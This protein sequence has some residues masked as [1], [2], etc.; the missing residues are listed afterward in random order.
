MSESDELLDMVDLNNKV[1]GQAKREKVFKEGLLHRAANIFIFN[2]KGQVYLQK[3][4]KKKLKYPLFWDMSAGEHVKAGES[5]KEAA[6]RGV[7]E[8]LGILVPLKK[9][10]P[11]HHM[12]SGMADKKD[13]LVDNE[14]I[15]TYQ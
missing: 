3:R 8:E 12:K 14:L 5:I 2:S 10:I 1:I 15:E 11:I 13:Q 4:S 7:K 6:S 9:V